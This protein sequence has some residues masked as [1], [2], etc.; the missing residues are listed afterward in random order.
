LKSIPSPPP[1][2]GWRERECSSSAHERNPAPSRAAPIAQP[3]LTHPIAAGELNNG[4]RVVRLDYI[5]A[6]R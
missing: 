4:E 5:A 3:P 6:M 2:A 1:D